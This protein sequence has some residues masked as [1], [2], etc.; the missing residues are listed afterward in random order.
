[1]PLD[2]PEVL[3]AFVDAALSLPLL[4][5]IQL[6]ACSLSPASAPALAR[7]LDSG[8][9]T[10]LFIHQYGLT[11][12]D[13]PAAVLL[14]DALHANAT[15]TSL[16]FRCAR[17]WSNHAAATALLSAL[18]GHGSL[19]ELSITG[20]GR[21]AQPSLEDRQHAGTL[22]GA[23]V[24]ADAPALTALH[25]AGSDLRD[26]GL[27]SLFEALP[28][29]THLRTLDCS[30]NDV[31]DEFAADVLLPAVRNNTSLRKLNAHARGR[32]SGAVR[33]AEALVASRSEAAPGVNA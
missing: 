30:D 16:T 15:L 8:T 13:A 27:R 23:L 4:R 12:L 11:L 22:L 3:D 24:A 6:L 1:M 33:E 10:E 9:L 26:A 21:D 28:A 17:P 7:L 31:S 5:T 20:V 32:Q 29:N 2:V 25:V 19:R 18:A 14:G